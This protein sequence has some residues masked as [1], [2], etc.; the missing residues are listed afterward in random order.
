MASRAQ[1][2][3]GRFGR[4]RRND[5]CWQGAK[6]WGHENLLLCTAIINLHVASNRPTQRHSNTHIHT[7]ITQRGVSCIWCGAM[8]FS[9]LIHNNTVQATYEDIALWS[10]C[11]WVGRRRQLQNC[12]VW[13]MWCWWWHNYDAM[14]QNGCDNNAVCSLLCWMSEDN[15]T[16]CVMRLSSVFPSRKLITINGKP[17]RCCFVWRVPC[18]PACNSEFPIHLIINPT[19]CITIIIGIYNAFIVLIHTGMFSRDVGGILRWWIQIGIWKRHLIPP[20]WNCHTG[21]TVNSCSALLAYFAQQTQWK[22]KPPLHFNKLTQSSRSCAMCVVGVLLCRI[23]WLV[24]LLQNI[25]NWNWHNAIKRQMNAFPGM[26]DNIFQY[27]SS[28]F[29]PV[30]I[31]VTIMPL[32]MHCIG[33]PTKQ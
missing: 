27:V 19:V 13:K 8:C 20:E 29:H 2:C 17:L 16:I 7:Q 31:G 32:S 18:C 30:G 10:I 12:L 25:C 28:C 6:E 11:D 9:S 26:M 23:R 1:C 22:T 33:R 4:C 5:E 14:A 24:F 15:G 21:M 3:R